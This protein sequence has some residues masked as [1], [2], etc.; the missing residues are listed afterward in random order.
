MMI[1]NNEIEWVKRLLQDR[2]V[3]LENNDRVLMTACALGRTE[4]VH[5]LLEDGRI[6]PSI[7][8]YRRKT[9]LTE[10]TKNG[11]I[12]VLK[13]LLADPRVDPTDNN[14][15]VLRIAMNENNED[16]IQLLFSDLRVAAAW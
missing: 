10:A 12:E 3:N 11:H 14:N 9:P 4:I 8:D 7:Q 1:E 13:L 6:N 2:R 15:Q 5:L 16:I